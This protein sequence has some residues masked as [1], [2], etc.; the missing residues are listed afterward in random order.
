MFDTPDRGLRDSS[1]VGRMNESLAISARRRDPAP[2]S[3]LRALGHHLARA[4]RRARRPEAGAA[5]HPLHDVR[6]PAPRARRAHRKCA[7][8]VGDVMGNYHPHG[9]SAIYDALVR[10]AQDFSLR[11]P[12]VDGQGNF[13]SLDGDRAGRDRYT[14]CK[15]QPLAVELLDELK[16][17]DRRRGGRTTTARNREPVVLPA[18]LRTCSS[19]A[20][21]A[22]PS[23][24]RPTS[25][26]T[27]SARW[28]RPASR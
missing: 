12:L 1:A 3:E 27:T 24:W 20:R 11:Y 25:R 6:R 28:S 10:M 22:S 9:D 2:L 5:P 14:E 26:R 18:R 19:T 16:H 13:G 4:A 8:V 17:E 7:A 15:L 23:A 21:R